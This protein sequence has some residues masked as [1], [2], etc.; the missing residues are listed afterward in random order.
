[1][2]DNGAELIDYFLA[3]LRDPASD[4]K[5]RAYAAT[6]LADRGSAGKPSDRVEVDVDVAV[7]DASRR[8]DEHIDRLSLQ[9]Q[10]ALHE[11]LGKLDSAARALPA[12]VIDAE[13]VEQEPA[14]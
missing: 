3:V 2:T 1:M 14:E 4:P 10:V 11:L 7:R 6:W 5:D 9:E 13:V 12:A 8:I